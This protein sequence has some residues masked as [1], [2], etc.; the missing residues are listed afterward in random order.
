MIGKKKLQTIFYKA[1]HEGWTA[2]KLAQS[3]AIGLY[4][5]FSPFPCLHLFMMFGFKWL[6][7]LNFPILFIVASINN[8][9]TMV[10]MYSLDYAFGYWLVHQIIGWSPCF[11]MPLGKWFPFFDQYLKTFLGSG[12]V[13]L[14]S[15]FIGGNILGILAAGVSYPILKII[16]TRIALTRRKEPL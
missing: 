1:L 9:W 14:S 10:P 5:A 3:V 12:S 7:G 15:F 8:P 4:I 13:C 6:L 11:I 16:F 2:S